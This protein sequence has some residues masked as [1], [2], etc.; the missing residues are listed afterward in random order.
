MTKTAQLLAL[1]EAATPGPW[2]Y[3]VDDNFIESTSVRSRISD[4]PAT[5]STDVGVSQ[6]HKNATFIAAANPQAILQMIAVME[7]MRDALGITYVSRDSDAVV[8]EA[9]S[10]Y[11]EL[12]G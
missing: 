5:R 4:W 6:C 11:K 7:Q 3:H 2:K 10:A 9:L 8:A 12:M 1:A